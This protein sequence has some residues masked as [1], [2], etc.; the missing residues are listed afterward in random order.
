MACVQVQQGV[1]TWLTYLAHD[2]NTGDPRTGITFNQ[3]DVSFKKA[4][5]LI[6]TLKVMTALD[7]REIGQGV[8]EVLFST[9][10]LN[11]VGSFLYVINGNGGLPAPAVRQ[12][13]GQAYVVASSAYTPGTVSL[14]TNVITGNIVDLRGVAVQDAAVSARV[15]AAPSIQG[16]VSP[17][18][19]GVTSD[20]IS[21]RTDAAGFFALELIQNS[22][23]DITIPRI[24]Y[25]RTLTVPDNTTDT[26]WDI[27]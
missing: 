24:N 13:I 5:D 16:L 20:L 3:V 15:L 7:F 10:E 6:F 1:A 18:I 27:P 12:F 9:S 11:T 19:A 14:P 25:R 23:V 4:G 17:N 2:V 8:Y 22:V 21:A 26:L